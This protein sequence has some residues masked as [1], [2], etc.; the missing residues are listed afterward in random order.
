M[1]SKL[2]QMSLASS[3]MWQLTDKRCFRSLVA[4][5]GRGWSKEQRKSWCFCGLIL[6]QH[7][8]SKLVG[9]YVIQKWKKC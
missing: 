3:Q 1:E 8:S 4:Y 9:K 7:S 5:L 6:T 2:V